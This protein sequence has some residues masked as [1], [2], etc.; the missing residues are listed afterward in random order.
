MYTLNVSS[1]FFLHL[2]HDSL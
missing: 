1:V 2:S